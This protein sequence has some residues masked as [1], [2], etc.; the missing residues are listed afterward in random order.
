MRAYVPSRV[1]LATHAATGRR[2]DYKRITD[3]QCKQ[4]QEALAM[5]FI[6]GIHIKE[7]APGHS[8]ATSSDWPSFICVAEILRKCERGHCD[9]HIHCIFIRVIRGGGANPQLVAAQVPVPCTP[10]QTLRT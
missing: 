5:M 9:K 3:Q 1:P 8:V 2:Q 4:I 6:S 7:R 10:Q